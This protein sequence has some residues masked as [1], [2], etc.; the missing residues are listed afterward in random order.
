MQAWAFVLVAI[1]VG[2]MFGMSAMGGI[3]GHTGRSMWWAL[4]LLPYPIGWVLGLTAVTMMLRRRP[5]LPAEA[6]H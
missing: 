1:G 4:A 5:D 2:L 3:G 6:Q